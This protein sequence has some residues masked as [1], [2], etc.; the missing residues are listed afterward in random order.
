M[1]ING[2]LQNATPWPVSIGRPDRCSASLNLIHVKTPSAEVHTLHVSCLCC[3]GWLG[4]HSIV[5]HHYKSHH[6]VRLEWQACE[7]RHGA[8]STVNII[9]IVARERLHL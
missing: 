7:Y 8:V 5:G 4:N 2:V 3:R 1:F 9:W 6:S